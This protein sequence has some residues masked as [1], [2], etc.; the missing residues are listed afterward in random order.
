MMNETVFLGECPIIRPEGIYYGGRRVIALDPSLSS[1]LS[2]FGLGDIGD[3]LAYRQEWE[4]FIAAHLALWRELNERF[5]NSPDVTR[6][7]AGI[8]K[9]SEIQNLEPTWRSF[10][11]SLALTRTYTSNT[12][13]LGILTQWN[14]W[15]DKSSAEI[16]ASAPTML[17]WYQDVVTRV[18]GPYKNDL[19]E[20]AKV[21]GFDI[22]LPDLPPF[23]VQQD[24]IARIQGAYTTTK[25]I[26]QIIG[27]GAGETIKLVSDTSQ[28]V[29][30]G[31]SDTARS[32]P[33]TLP[34]IGAAAAVAVVVVGGALIVHYIPKQPTRTT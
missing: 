4:P 22:K 9:N 31:L 26:L 14:A 21:W 5:E 19:M 8:F 28:A 13:P 18:A 29:S 25:G 15:K 33:R 6:C 2:G 12:H 27:Y 7:P 24:I 30:E 10:C 34:W 17:K 20:I 16:L 1:G 3:L 23:G 32:L 11:A